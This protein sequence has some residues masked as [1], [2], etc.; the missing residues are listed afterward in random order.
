MQNITEVYNLPG[1]RHKILFTGN[2]LACSCFSTLYT[3][4]DYVK[5]FVEFIPDY[6]CLWFSTGLQ[7]A[8]IFLVIRI[9]FL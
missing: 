4:F 2:A 3:I 1:I 7:Y 6:D 5:F 9:Q 8:L